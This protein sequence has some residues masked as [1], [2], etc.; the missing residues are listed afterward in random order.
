M[1]PITAQILRDYPRYVENYHKVLQRREARQEMLDAYYDE[2]GKNRYLTLAVF[3]AAHPEW[4][5]LE[6]R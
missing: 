4:A 6:E 3:I 1:H 5:D 2:W